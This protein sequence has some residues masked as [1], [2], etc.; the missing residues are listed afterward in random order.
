MGNEQ[1]MQCT[2][3]EVQSISSTNYA[4][5]Q[6]DDPAE[7]E[8]LAKAKAMEGAAATAEREAPALEEAA[9]KAAQQKTI[10]QLESVAL[11]KAAAEAA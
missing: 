4:F 11:E 10:E 6:I 2:G 5:A 9:A 1:P 7:Q 8:E 3:Q